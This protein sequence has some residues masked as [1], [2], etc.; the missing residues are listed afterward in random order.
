MADQKKFE[1][2][3]SKP[4]KG[5]PYYNTKG[6][7]GYSTA[8]KG[9]PTDSGCDVLANC[10]G[11]ALGRFNEIGGY[12]SCKY[13][14][15]TN[16][17]NFANIAKQQGLTVQQKPT[18]GGCMVWA[19]GKVGNST[20]GAG[21][22]AIVEQINADGSI[23]TSESGWNCQNPFW[24][25]T[26]SGSNWGQS[27]SYSYVGCVVNPAVTAGTT[28]A[29]PTPSTTTSSVP[30]D[31]VKKGSKGDSVK[32]VQQKLVKAGY[33]RANEVD[34]SFGKITLGAALAF[35]LENGLDPDGIC[36]A[37]TKEKLAKF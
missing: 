3:L 34:G 16:A 11:Y 12:G 7:G 18:L 37:K 26:R 6:N 23:V 20:D 13:L 9:K 15:N 27:S 21:H 10:V 17:E 14:G 22:V 4:T 28:T 24:T 32:W 25:K 31:T 8:I 35:Q 19:K 29:A 1:P 33:L 5:N 2:R 30:K 36:G